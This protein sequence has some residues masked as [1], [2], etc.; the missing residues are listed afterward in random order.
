MEMH[1]FTE[2]EVQCT[3]SQGTFSSRARKPHKSA[4]EVVLDAKIGS[5][6]PKKVL[7]D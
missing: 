3:P 1:N 2:I 5:N 6:V 4:L 7:C